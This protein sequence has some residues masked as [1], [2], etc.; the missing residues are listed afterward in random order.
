[1]E[2]YLVKVGFSAEAFFDNEQDGIDFIDHLIKVCHVRPMR[3]DVI[4]YSVWGGNFSRNFILYDKL[5]EVYTR[6]V[7]YEEFTENLEKSKA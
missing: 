5:V 3:D 4:T 6:Q 2:I 1:M 7:A